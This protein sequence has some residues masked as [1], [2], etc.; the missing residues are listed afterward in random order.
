MTDL[1]DYLSTPHHWVV[2]RLPLFVTY[3]VVIA[4][5]IERLTR[6]GEPTPA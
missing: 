1:A 6:R 3:L 2:F 4:A 5:G